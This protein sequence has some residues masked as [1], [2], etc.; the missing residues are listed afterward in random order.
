MVGTRT[1]DNENGQPDITTII[2]QQ[3]Q[4]IISQIVTQVTNNVN[5]ENN[6]NNNGNNDNNNRNGGN[7]GC[8]YMGFQACGPKEYDEKGGAIAL[9]RWIK[10]MELVI[11]NSRC[12]ENQ[13]VRYAASSFLNK[14]L[15]WWNTQ[16]Q[17]RGREAAIGMTWNDFKALLVEEFCPSN[18]MERKEVEEISKSGGSWKENKKAKVGTG[19]VATTPPKNE[20]VNQYPKCT[21]CYTYH[22]EDGVCRLCFN[23]QRPGHF[24]KDYRAPFKRATPVSAVRRGHNR[25]ACYECG[26]P[27]SPSVQLPQVVLSTWSSRKSLKLRETEIL[28]VQGERTLGVAKALMNTKVDELKVS[29]ISVIRDFVNVFP[30][31]LSR[32]P[33]QRQLQELQD[34]GFIRPSHS[35]WGAPM[36]FFK[37]KDGSFRMCIDYRELN[38]LTVKNRYPL[39]RIDDYLITTRLCY[40]SNKIFI[41]R[42]ITSSE[43]MRRYST[44]RISNKTKEDHEL[45]LRLVLELLRKEKLYAKFFKCYYRR[46]IIDFF[47][48]AKPLTS[49][50]QKNQRY[51]WGVEQE[52]AFQT[53]KN[54]LCDALILLLPDGVEDFVVYFKNPREELYNTQSRVGSDGVCSKNLETLF[55]CDY[56]CKIHYH[57]DKANVVA[58]ALSRKERVKPKRVRAMAMTIQSRVK[59]MILSAQGEAFIGNETCLKDMYWWLGLKRDIDTY[60]SECLT[61]ENVKARHQRPSG[62][63][64]QPK[65]LEWKWENITMDFITKLPRIRSRH[66]A[67]WV[68]VDRLTK[69]AHFLAIRKDYSTEK[70]A[71]LYTDEIVVRH[72]VHSES[73]IQTLKD[74]LRAYVIDFGDSWDFH[75]PLAEFSY[76]NSYH[77]SIRCALFE[78]LYGRK[79]RS[80]VLW[81]EIE[82]GCFIGPKLVQETTDKVVLIKEKLQAAR[83]RQKSYADS[84]L[85]MTEYAGP[86]E[87]LERIDPVAYQL[88][89][90]EELI[91]VHDTFHVSNLKKCLGNANLHVPE[92]PLVNGSFEVQGGLEFTWECEDYMKS[93]YP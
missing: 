6:N 89:L 83:D 70:L 74:M 85:K 86:F 82:E 44:N 3:L 40:F 62:L 91:G 4:N 48:I 51:V 79:R 2:A 58:D 54:N 47:K 60:V 57:P 88:R 52:E 92:N 21:K 43:Y 28:R 13:K 1:N 78:A 17:A 11:D 10:K 34:K 69:S 5:N 65:I 50:T 31:D 73:T 27:K 77:T 45:H 87:I 25:K 16:I 93:K 9:T 71:R 68:V 20:F 61:C 66:D 22:L 14:A 81:A 7:N 46:F 30:E 90:P 76:N 59:G 56:E 55:V 49:L 41:D 24:A 53:L 29:D 35:Q 63:L 38:K 18:E 15:T 8:S 33:P 39:P 80:L 72:G 23:C 26:S 36:L 19:F 32:L 84:G 37:K 42:V 64:Q 12:T 75:L 67:I